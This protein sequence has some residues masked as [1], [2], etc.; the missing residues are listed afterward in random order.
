M[1][2]GRRRRNSA[3][4]LARRRS[5]EKALPPG[6]PRRRFVRVS[7]R[8]GAVSHPRQV[9][10]AGQAA[11]LPGVSVRP[12]SG[13]PQTG[14]QPAVQLP[15]GG[16]QQGPACEPAGPRTQADRRAH[17]P[18]HSRPD[19]G[20]GHYAG[21]PRRV[22]RLPP[23]RECAR[24]DSGRAGRRSAHPN[25]ACR[26]LGA[27]RLAIEVRRGPRQSARRISEH[28]HGSGEKRDRRAA[29]GPAGAEPRGTAAVPHAGRPI[30][31]DRHV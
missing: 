21:S 15:F 13:R 18:P 8:Q 3:R 7:R 20:A 14:A 19:S 2:R 24:Y 11:R 4:G 1:D 22:V 31:A 25:S 9:R 12:A 16:R 17:G 23:L 27:A 10:R 30:L 26:L 28:R 6:P 5:L 29:D